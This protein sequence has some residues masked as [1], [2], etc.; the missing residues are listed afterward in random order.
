M[1]DQEKASPLSG[2]PVGPAPALYTRIP[3]IDN[4]IVN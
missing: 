3:L 2:I 1:P 4:Q